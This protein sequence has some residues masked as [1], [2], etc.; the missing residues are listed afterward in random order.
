LASKTRLD[1][2]PSSETI[3]LSLFGPGYGE[4]CLV[5][6]GSN[7]WLIVDSCKDQRSGANPALD[8]LDRIGVDPSERVKLIV[9]SHAH[10]DHI[11]GL[12]K[13]VKRCESAEFCTSAALTKDQF[14]TLLEADEEISAVSRHSAYAEFREISNILR[15]RADKRNKYPAYQ[16]AIADRPLYY[17]PADESSF[18]VRITSLSPSD[19][20]VTRAM[21]YFASQ[22]P[23]PG[24][25]PTRVAVA[26]PNTLTCVLWL[27]IG[28][29]CILLGGDL[30][31]GPGQKCGWNAVVNSPFRPTQLASVFKVSHHGSSNA[32]HSEVWDKMLTNQP[33]AMLTPWRHG[34]G[35]LPADSD[36]SRICTIT[37]DAFITANPRSSSSSARTKKIAAQLSTTARHV[38]EVG[39]A[40]QVRARLSSGASRWMVELMHPAQ[41]LCI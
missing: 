32:H 26:D 28:D 19:E 12:S 13:I 14:F 31:N 16:W 34:S 6:L 23:I 3:E 33:L 37:T 2:P 11:A 39:L 15:E 25:Q 9:A 7:D 17:R 8:Y 18:R 22:V 20:A 24:Q 40:G 10:D 41:R 27:E 30:E 5:H 1:D 36:I 35:Q 4:C 29:T 21:S 38:S